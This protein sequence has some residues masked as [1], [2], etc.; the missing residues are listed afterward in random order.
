VVHIDR[1]V[2]QGF[3]NSRQ[4]AA[5]FG[6]APNGHWKAT[7]AALV[8]LVRCRNTV[9]GAGTRPP[10][11]IVR[12]VD[13]GWYFAGH[14]TPSIAESRENFRISARPSTRSGTVSWGDSIATEASSPTAATNLMN[15]DAVGTDFRLYP[16]R[17]AARASRCRRRSSAMAARR[18]GA[19]PGPGG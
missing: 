6:G 4:T 12:E 3:M 11:E 17:T 2:F 1:G 9:F 10:E 15:V 7:D 18:C 13:R 14:R 8:P 16:S 19:R 5:I